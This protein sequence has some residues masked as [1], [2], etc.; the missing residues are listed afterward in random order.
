[1][2]SILSFFTKKRQKTGS[3]EHAD[4]TH[5][6]PSRRAGSPTGT[7]SPPKSRAAR[8]KSTRVPTTKAE[9]RVSLEGY[10]LR[11][12]SAASG[13]PKSTTPPRITIDL[14][15]DFEGTAGAS[16]AAGSSTLVG[17]H[18]LSLGLDA[19]GGTPTITPAERRL[20]DSQRYSASDLRA[21]WEWLGPQV[22][23]RGAFS[24][25]T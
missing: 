8:T 13:L 22:Q 15:F 21:A 3:A 16:S 25:H 20:L 24:G 18:S 14:P 10:G 4:A 5:A 12:K 1:M 2:V 9:R 17:S 19:V 6:T 11:R 23:D 7:G